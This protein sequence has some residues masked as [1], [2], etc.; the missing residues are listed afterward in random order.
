MLVR[1]YYINRL[2][3]ETPTDLRMG[4]PAPTNNFATLSVTLNETQRTG[5]INAPCHLGQDPRKL[6]EYPSPTFGR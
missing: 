3:G 6:D 4:V 5:A 1:G 2:C